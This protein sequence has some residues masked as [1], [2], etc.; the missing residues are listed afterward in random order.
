MKKTTVSYIASLG[1]A[2]ALAAPNVSDVSYS[3]DPITKAMTVTYTLSGE[4]GIPIL[5]IRTNGV[6]IGWSNLRGA[7]GDVHRLVQPGTGRKICWNPV[8]AWPEK[9]LA[10]GVTA[11]VRVYPE[12]N[13]PD[14]MVVNCEGQYKGRAEAVQYFVSE[15]QL[16]EGSLNRPV[17]KTDKMAFR[18]VPAAGIVW[19]MGASASDMGGRIPTYEV[20]RKVRLTSN[21][22]LGV[23]EVTQ[24]QYERFMNVNPSN[25]K[26]DGAMRPVENVSWAD[27]RG[28]TSVWPG[29]TRAAAYGSVTAASF[30]GKMR[31]HV[32]GA[33]N[34]DLPTEA[35][36]EFACRAGSGAAFP[37]GSGLVTGSEESWPYLETHARYKNN[38]KEDFNG[39]NT[40]STN[41]ASAAVGT[42]LPNRWGFYDMHGNMF[43]WTLDHYAEYDTSDDIID[44][45]CGAA[46]SAGNTNKRT[47]R[48]GSYLLKP[49]YSRCAYRYEGTQTQ[50]SRHFG[51]RACLPLE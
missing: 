23:F 27:V 24:S 26:T 38:Y 21:Y 14:I 20:Q 11:V 3:Q 22:Y 35:Q 45:P 31:A 36:W 39:A 34:F 15:A 48:G 17:Y 41:V 4:A 29:E 33:L 46:D 30:F 51:F 28:V 9:F 1:A 2:A 7:Y 19:R 49:Y 40:L 43:E 32:G 47:T 37:D 6:S 42:Y 25:F 50:G 12:N 44:N 8:K 18:K 5:D 13:P 16:P 10:S